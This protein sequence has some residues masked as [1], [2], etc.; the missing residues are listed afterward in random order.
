MMKDKEGVYQA[1]R[2][3]ENA[4]ISER[5]FMQG[6]LIKLQKGEAFTAQLLLDNWLKRHG[7]GG[8]E[9]NNDNERN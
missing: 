1:L 7:V 6:V 4:L 5:R 9:E 2:R 3:S 8:E